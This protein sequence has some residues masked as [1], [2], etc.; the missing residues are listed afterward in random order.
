MHQ[1]SASGCCALTEAWQAVATHI[2]LQMR[3]MLLYMTLFFGV[4]I[5]AVAL[6]TSAVKLDA[7]EI[8]LAW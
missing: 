3:N 4:L 1:S 6:G 2:C 5:S 7:D 8:K